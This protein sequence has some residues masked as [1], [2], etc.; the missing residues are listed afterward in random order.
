ML[1]EVALHC[2]APAAL[3]E[4]IHTLHKVRNCGMQ[5]RKVQLLPVH[6]SHQHQTLICCIRQQGKLQY[7]LAGNSAKPVPD[8][9]P[10][11]CE[12]SLVLEIRLRVLKIATRF[13]MNLPKGLLQD[14]N[15]CLAEL[16]LEACGAQ[17]L[18]QTWAEYYW[19]NW[20]KTSLWSMI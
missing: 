14:S 7:I 16:E 5:C 12:E 11:S 19:N 8:Q 2:H 15:R 17:G 6:A 9:A 3:E 4:E 18:M 20:R 13:K 1:C 10:P